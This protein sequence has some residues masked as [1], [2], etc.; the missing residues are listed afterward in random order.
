VVKAYLTLAMIASLFGIFQT[1]QIGGFGMSPL[2]TSFVLFWLYLPLHLFVARKPLRLPVNVESIMLTL[3]T[4]WFV[5]SMIS[6]VLSGSLVTITQ[7]LKTTLHFLFVVGIMYVYGTVRFT[8]ALVNQL[9]R[10]FLSLG[11]VVCIYGIYQVPA[12]I[13]DLPLAWIDITNVSFQE[14]LEFASGMA[15]LALK[16]ENFYRATSIFSEPSALAF[17]ASLLLVSALVPLIRG[18][19]HFLRSRWSISLSIITSFLALF[20]AFSMTGVLVIMGSLLYIVVRY[21]RKLMRKILPYF[22]YGAITLVV[23]DS[24]VDSF[25]DVSVL[26]MFSVRIESYVSGAAFNEDVGSIVGESA[27]QRMGDAAVATE[28]WKDYPFVGVGPGCLRHE[29]LAQLNQ[30]RFVSSGFFTVLSENGAIGL[31]LFL[32]VLLTFLIVP[33]VLEGRWTAQGLGELEPESDA[34]VGVVP[35]LVVAFILMNVSGNSVVNAFYWFNFLPIIA[36]I[37]IARRRLGLYEEIELFMWR[38]TER[39][40][41]ETHVTT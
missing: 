12:R 9:M 17:Y 10:L 13:F 19:K 1:M 11:T 32:G 2:E 5:F 30:V 24:T 40:G 22:A 31:I 33:T 21:R 36:G 3:F 39:K 35:P 23:V 27:T 4:V 29:R 25:F 7:T 41:G 38:G 16:F 14:D 8:P 18:S 15:Q 34:I 37:Q 26:N 28:I 6:P 20:L